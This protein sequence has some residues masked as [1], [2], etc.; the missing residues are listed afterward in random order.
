MG[1]YS[2]YIGL[3]DTAI[4]R[5]IGGLDKFSCY[6]A[7]AVGLLFLLAYPLAASVGYLP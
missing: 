5:K 1:G 4:H 2:N 7:A 3:S 6:F